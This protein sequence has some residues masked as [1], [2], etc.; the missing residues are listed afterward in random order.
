MVTD[1]PEK[2]D[3]VARKGGKTLFTKIKKVTKRLVTENMSYRL[4]NKNKTCILDL[5]LSDGETFEEMI[6]RKE[7]EI[8][9]NRIMQTTKWTKVCLF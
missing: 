5:E 9:K 1:T 6:E 7:Q 8:M 4:S 2:E 3:I